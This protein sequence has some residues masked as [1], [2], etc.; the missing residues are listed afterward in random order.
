MLFVLGFAASCG[1]LLGDVEV[2]GDAPLTRLGPACPTTITVENATPLC[3]A[4]E[5]PV[6][7]EEGTTRCDDRL[8]QLCTDTGR[9]WVTWQQ[10]A[11]AALCEASDLS[12]VAACITPKCG[13]EQ[14][15]CEGNVLRLCTEDRTGWQVF[16]TCKTAAHCDA[17]QRQC[18]PAPCDPGDRRCNV[19]KLERCRNDQMDWEELDQ[20]ATNEVCE[21]TLVGTLPGATQGGVEGQVPLPLA[22][23]AAPGTVEEGPTECLA[24]ACL[25]REVKCDG[26][27]LLAC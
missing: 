16:D 5:R 19:G 26:A 11:S 22:P 25:N 4:P 9:A 14:M 12:T 27:Q 18:L 8:L 17:G 3:P 7:C 23:P 24:A 1:Q 6:I 15:S 13:V 2:A 20:C 10:C 21:A